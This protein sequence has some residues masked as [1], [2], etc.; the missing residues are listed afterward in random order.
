MLGLRAAESDA[1]QGC[2]QLILEE[3]STCTGSVICF[4]FSPKK[5]ETL[6]LN[7]AGGRHLIGNDRVFLIVSCCIGVWVCL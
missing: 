1:V 3:G 7:K 6:A 4:V 2:R 5:L